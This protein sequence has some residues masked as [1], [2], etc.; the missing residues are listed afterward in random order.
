LQHGHRAA[1]AANK[2]NTTEQAKPK[3]ISVQIA[4]NNPQRNAEAEPDGTPET[5]LAI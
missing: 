4:G 1:N 3:S 2:E 5:Y